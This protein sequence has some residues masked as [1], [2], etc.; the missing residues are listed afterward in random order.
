MAIVF[1]A[2]TRMMRTINGM[3]VGESSR[4]GL[5]ATTVAADAV[6]ERDAA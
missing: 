6:T 5:G 4:A 2:Q 1:E 3:R